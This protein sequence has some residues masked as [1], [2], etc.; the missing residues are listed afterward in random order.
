MLNPSDITF[1]T[2][3]GGC[4]L[5][6]IFYGISVR[7]S[8]KWLTPMEVVLSHAANAMTLATIA[9]FMV[10][11]GVSV[12]SKSWFDNDTPPVIENAADPKTSRLLPSVRSPTITLD[13]NEPTAFFAF[14]YAFGMIVAAVR[15]SI[16][17]NSKPSPTDGAPTSPP[18]S[19]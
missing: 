5:A 3:F 1:W 18:P 13:G 8:G 12:V 16:V 19:G 10:N 17:T 9:C 7:I 14:L 6:L 11:L 2:I 4:G 15:R